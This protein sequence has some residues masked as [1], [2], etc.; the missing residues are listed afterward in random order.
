[1]PS[2]YRV[3][4]EVQLPRNTLS[5]CRLIKLRQ[6]CHWSTVGSSLELLSTYD[7]VTVVPG[8][9]ILAIQSNSLQTFV[10]LPLGLLYRIPGDS[11]SLY[12]DEMAYRWVVG[13]TSD[14]EAWVSLYPKDRVIQACTQLLSKIS[15]Q[16]NVPSDAVLLVRD[17][18]Y[19]V[20]GPENIETAID[21]AFSLWC[22]N[23]GDA[24][25]V[26]ER[27]VLLSVIA[28]LRRRKE[29]PDDDHSPIL[30]ALTR[31]VAGL[32]GIL[33]GAGIRP[34]VS[35]NAV[36]SVRE[37]TY[38]VQNALTAWEDSLRN[39]L[40]VRSTSVSPE[41]PLSSAVTGESAARGINLKALQNLK[42]LL[43]RDEGGHP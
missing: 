16:A 1:M 7:R 21:N 27:E 5:C 38:S 18:L 31:Q 39:Q 8:D 3:A 13:Y 35:Q 23:T 25:R 26:T 19:H 9:L 20:Q 17:I 43:K 2:N 36:Q 29:I 41:V 33:Q 14:I 37:A 32:S 28:I 22:R 34:G 24:F 10:C 6:E 15:D 12:Y 11:V 42:D 30:E 4:E 40:K